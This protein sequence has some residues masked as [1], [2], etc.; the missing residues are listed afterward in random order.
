MVNLRGQTLLIIAAHADDE[1]L[2]CAGLINKVKEASGKVFVLF[3][4]NGTTYDFT[5]KG[6]S[7]EEE[8]A[9]EIEKVAKFLGYDGYHIAFP[10]NKFHL[11]LDEL[12]Q[13]DLMDEIERGPTSLESVNPTILAFPS[14]GD[15]NQDHRR[16][17]QAAFASCRPIPGMNKKIPGIVLS[18]EHTTGGWGISSEGNPNF[19]V[20]LSTQD[21]KK[22]IE[23]LN[24]YKSQVRKNPHPRSAE[25]VQALAK[26]RG[27]LCGAEA[28]EAFYLHRLITL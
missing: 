11:R 3:L 24:L 12:S 26:L 4:T 2:G 27:A 23:A 8:R 21:M 9:G 13:K 1:I 6:I 28:A 5:K 16:A 10:G 19:F 22:K 20:P 18:Y 15:Y 17:A 25:I 7:T 14:L